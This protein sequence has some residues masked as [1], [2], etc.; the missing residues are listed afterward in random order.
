MTL[1]NI[2]PLVTVFG[3]SGFLGR[4]VV[5]ALAKRGYRIRV[6]VRRPD[7]A[8]FL[9]PLGNV[10]Q[11]TFVQANLRYPD[12]VKNAVSGASHVVNCVGLLFESGKNKFD[13]VQAKG[14]ALVAEAARAEGAALTHVSAI[15][16]S[17]SAASSYARTKAAGERAVQDT[18]G[19]AVILRPSL[20][21]GT[22]D[23]FFNKFA[24]MT[25][26]SPFLPLIGG[27]RT[28][29]QPVY[30]GD[31]AEA[32]A[33]SVEGKL[34][35]GAIYE[36]GGRDVVDFRQ[37]LEMI[38]KITGRKRRLVSVPFGLASL[39]AGIASAVPL[40]RPPVTPDQIRLLKHDNVV[41]AE[42]IAEGRTLEAAG[43]TPVVLGSVLPSYLVQYR[44]HGQFGR[45]A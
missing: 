2:P 40:V 23:Q 37:C 30:V 20:V 12:S 22:E 36:L 15:G 21:F 7:L 41:S 9:Q 28:K 6:A 31:V 3:G 19:D 24:A 33:L 39:F 13:S 5:R 11:I 16:A 17:A 45:V 27:G 34:V 44:E 26:S 8:G 14:A 38:L 43:I 1:S 35:N 4:Y 25:L 10:G 29:F 32:V 42:A 18:L